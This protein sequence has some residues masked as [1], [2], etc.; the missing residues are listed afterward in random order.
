[1]YVM[2]NREIGYPSDLCL[3]QSFSLGGMYVYF[4]NLTHINVRSSFGN[5]RHNILIRHYVA[6]A[7]PLRHMSRAGSPNHSV[8]ECLLQR[9]MDLVADAFNRGVI[10]HN[11]CFAE[12]RVFPLA[13]K[14]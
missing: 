1:M 11:Q 8:F 10:P 4:I 14:S 13:V 3:E 6:Q 7:D 12:V 5:N 9:P 2:T